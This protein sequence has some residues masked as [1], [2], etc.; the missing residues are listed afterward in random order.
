MLDVQHP[1]Q[2]QPRVAYS[3]AMYWVQFCVIHISDLPDIVDK[4]SHVFRFAD[5]T[6]L[7]REI[8]SPIDRVRV[9]LQQDPDNPTDWSN[10]WLLKFH[11]N[12]CVLIIISRNSEVRDA[13][14][15]T[16]KHDLNCSKEKDIDVFIDNTL[17][18]DIHVIYVVSKANMVLAKTRKTFEC[19]D[20]NMFNQI[21]KTPV[22]PHLE[23]T[24][25]VW[26]PH[27]TTRKE[28][29]ENVQRR[30]TKMVPGLS[31]LS[32]PERLRKLNVPTLAYR[33]VRLISWWMISMVMINHCHY[34]YKWAIQDSMVTKKNCI[35]E[36]QK[37]DP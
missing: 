16:K 8:N 25:P 27:L 3:K 26:S 12:K 22:R 4:D 37:K 14:Y 13:S 17:N 6:K 35:N 30:A 10:K 20:K 19:M 7:F 1:I 18:F 23:Y 36:E 29:L 21:F 32:Y 15:I 2:P 31:D 28:I 24:A 9:I 34:C 33:R 5:D 11:A